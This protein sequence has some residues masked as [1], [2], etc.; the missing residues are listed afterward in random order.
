MRRII[1]VCL[2]NICRS[3][4]AEYIFKSEIKSLNLDGEFEVISRATSYEEV[5]NDIY[6]PMKRELIKNQ[7]PLGRH[8]A[9][10]ITQKDYDWADYIFYMEE[11]NKRNLDYI[12]TDTR[13]IIKPIYYF[14]PSVNRIEDPW[15]SDRYELVVSQ[16]KQC[17]NDILNNILKEGK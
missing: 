4:A 10:R 3:P 13:N 8:S 16:I 17:I 9:T 7:I 12:L 2:G 15:Y 6:P 5:G 11:T 1:F 14:T